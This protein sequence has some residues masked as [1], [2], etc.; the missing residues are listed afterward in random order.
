M[1]ILAQLTNGSESDEEEEETQDD[2]PAADDHPQ[3]DQPQDDQQSES[4]SESDQSESQSEY[5][6]E[7][8]RFELLPPTPRIDP[9]GRLAG[10]PSSHPM[11]PYPRT[12]K[13]AYPQR[14]C[15]V[16]KRKAGRR[17]DTR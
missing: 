5:E 6:D 9:P 17:V 1:F 14:P 7:G 10:P 8:P 16:C 12:P 2:Q 11:V 13:K 4:Q 15:R 3:D